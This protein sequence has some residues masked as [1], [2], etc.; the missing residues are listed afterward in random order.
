M[1]SIKS[2]CLYYLSIISL[3]ILC[4]NSCANYGLNVAHDKQDWEEHFP[5]SSLAITHTM[6]LIGDA[7]NSLPDQ[8]A[9]PLALLEKMLANR[10]DSASVLFLGDNIY[11]RGLPPKRFGAERKLAE[12][13]LLAQLK[14]LDNK[15]VRPIFMPGNH[16]WR[17]YG[18]K[19]L[20]RQEDY[21]EEYFNKGIADEDDWENYFL[22]D[23]GCG[24]P[25]LVE[26]NDNLVVIVMDSQ[27]WLLD[28]NKEPRIN[29]G[30]EAKSRKIFAFLFEEMVR[31]NRHKNIVIAMHHPPYSNGTHGGFY[32]TR[33]HLFP[34]TD[35]NEDL[36]IPIPIIGSLG[37]LYRGMVGSKQDIA[38]HEYKEMRNAVINA[39]KKN[40]KFIFASG[41]EHNLQF[42]K[43]DGQAYIVSG[44]GSKTGPT[45][46][47]NG[48]E[49]A[50]GRKGLAQ[51]DFYEDGSAWV[52]FYVV[53]AN[54]NGRLVYRQKI[55]GA[56]PVLEE[57]KP[58][59]FDVYYQG[60]DSIESFVLNKEVDKKGPIHKL[61]LG[62]HYR[63]LYTYKY[64]FPVLDLSTYSGGLKPVKRG[65]GN[66]TNSLRLKDA[67]GRQYVLRAMTK[68]AT[69]FIPYPFNKIAAAEFIVEDNFLSTHPFAAIVVS[70]LA[71]AV[72]VYHT[73]PKLYF[74]PSQPALGSYNDQFGSEIYLL[75]ERPAG[76]W[77]TLASFG[78][79]KK[80]IGTP[81]LA[82]K[83]IEDHKHYIDQEWVIKSRLFDIVIGDWDRHDDQWRWASFKDNAGKTFYRPIPRDRDQPFSKYDGLFTA[84]ARLT[85][86]FLKQLQPYKAD[87]GNSK[88]A[89]YNARQFDKTFL[90]T[91]SWE[92]WKAAAEKIQIQLTDEVIESAFQ[93]W[94]GK[95][96][97]ESAKEVISIL[98]KRR[99]NLLTMARKHYLLIAE[100]VDVYGSD[101]RDLFE[102]DRRS[103]EETVVRVYDTNKE[104]E[105]E[106]LLYE[107]VFKAKETDGIHIYGLGGED[108]FK[109]SGEV[110]K[111]P[112]VRIV[113]G[114]D[115][116]V[117][118]DKSKVKGWS[119]KTWVYDTPEVNV[120]YPGPDTK[121]KFSE[122]REWNLYNRKDF[123]YEYDFLVPFPV[124][125]YNPDD[126]FFLGTNLTFTNYQYKKVPYGQQHVLSFKYAFDTKAYNF[127]YSG[128]FLEALGA[129]DLLLNAV[130]QAPSY[131]INYFG[132]G[133]ESERQDSDDGNSINFYRVRQSLY[134]LH[135]AFKKS[136]LGRTGSI[137]LGPLVE[138]VRIDRTADRFITSPDNGLPPDIFESKYYGGVQLGFNLESIDKLQ[139]T[140]RGLLFTSSIGYKTNLE[141]LSRD[142]AFWKVEM[143]I[144]QSLTQ[145]DRLVLAT[146]IGTHK[147]AGTFDFF[148][149]AMLGGRSNLRAL[150]ANRYYGRSNYYHNTDLRLKL[151][152]IENNIM[153][154]SLGLIGGFDYGRVWLKGE[155]SNTWHTA[156]GGGIWMAPID[157][158]I[159]RGTLF[160]SKDEQR[161]TIGVGYDF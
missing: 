2:Y 3:L 75:E 10:T 124:I 160:K 81:D 150:P 83:I 44:A 133:N 135:P 91:L 27:W 141:Q 112:K 89:N 5:D 8:I 61:L 67:Q 159:L 103:D 107:R 23:R 108:F 48:A 118:E 77:S 65:G 158:I 92:D 88:W 78:N 86:P 132:L 156:Y 57:P 52:K 161:L 105:R 128:E 129:N 90:N 34:L 24:G 102:V 87:V 26:I 37:S 25:E 82:E 36:M 111:G 145:S 99:D 93:V 148:Q 64:K 76:N 16:D 58:K 55:K 94:P 39:A 97:D 33:Q 79:S 40:G 28:W 19:G 6:F 12:D 127:G 84:M 73:N 59:T 49:F 95:A 144:Y 152:Y 54:G 85:L 131:T 113:G 72:D 47:G 134:S 96:Y 35:I 121:N 29:D 43:L 123:H 151:V 53:K 155:D 143:K 15:K 114:L 125:G 138:R 9:P 120:L 60:L 126:G 31:K 80:I 136:F 137:T 101:K 98:K 38:H 63:D 70:Q 74:V 56:L 7:G 13:R 62:E 149:S 21:V 22:P 140:T 69:R 146:R 104:G 106:E 18:L 30:C 117:F 32:T 157:Y 50:Y 46:L 122:R 100:T 109:L 51:M 14:I 119:K 130:F 68:D 142:F 17:T 11:P 66:Q 4:L 116:D 147:N 20:R 71:E 41:H 115:V 139:M 45:R 1:L 110:R 154:F 153:P 42:F